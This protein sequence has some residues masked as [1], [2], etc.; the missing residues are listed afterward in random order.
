MAAKM[1]YDYPDASAVPV[2]LYEGT[3]TKANVIKGGLTVDDAITYNAP[4]AKGDYV[5]IRSDENSGGEIVVEKVTLGSNEV[6]DI[7]GVVIDSPSGDDQVTATGGTPAHA[8]RRVATVMFFGHRIRMFDVTIAGAIRGGYSILYSESAAG[9]VEG[10]AT[11]ANG[12][13]VACAYAAAGSVIPVLLG[14]YGFHPGD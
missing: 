8:Q 2:K 6:N 1:L 11:L 7:H 13:A 14:Y 9:V 4:I 5:K 10:S 12:D 3:I